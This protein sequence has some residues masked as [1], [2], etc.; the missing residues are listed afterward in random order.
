MSPQRMRV[1]RVLVY[2]GPRDW[3]EHTLQQSWVHGQIVY[4]NS[5]VTETILGRFVY[6]AGKEDETQG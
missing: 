2:D 5:K 4:G 3:V 1:I 6:E